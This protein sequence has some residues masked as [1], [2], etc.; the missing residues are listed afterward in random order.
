MV[1]DQQVRLLRKYMHTEP[2]LSIAA[3]KAGMDEKTVVDISA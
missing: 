1:T 2:T 3:A